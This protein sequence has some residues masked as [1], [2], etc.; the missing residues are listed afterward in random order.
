MRLGHQAQ[1]DRGLPGAPRP[2]A[3]PPP[4]R[5]AG[6][7]VPR[8]QPQ[9][10]PLL[11]DAAE[12]HGRPGRHRRRHQ[13]RRRA[14]AADHPG[15][16]PGRVHQEGQGE[17]A[18]LHGGLGPPEAERP[19]PAHRPVQG[20]LQGPATSGSRSSSPPCRG[21][22]MPSFRTGAVTELLSER[23][24][25]QRVRVDLG[26]D[27]P[28]RA[29]VLTQLTGP[30]AVGDRVV[31][32]TT[33]VELGLGTGGWHVVHWNLARESWSEPGPGH[34]MKLRYTSLQADTGAGEEQHPDVP[35]TL[36]GT[37]VVVCTVHSQVP[38]VVVAALAA[39]PGT[40]IA[41]VMTDG[42]ALPLAFSDLTA[43]HG[44]AGP[45]GRHGHGRARLRRRPRGGQR[46]LRP[47]P[48]PPRPRRRADRRRHGPRRGRHRHRRWAPPR[49]RRPR[50]LDTVAALGG[51]PVACLRVSS[52]DARDRHQGVSHHTRT[53]L[54]LVR[55][56]VLVAADARPRPDRAPRG[57][58]RST[59]PTPP[60]S[61][62]RRASTSR[63]WAAR[64]TRTPPTS[65]PPARPAC[66][67]HSSS[68]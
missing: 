66:W 1:P 24:G 56:P 46:G 44:R 5:P 3:G 58:R 15:P 51:R 37:P 38:C 61:W 33:A 53:V 26:D 54:D 14:P 8:R 41:Y 23:A 64:R 63:P 2:A 22:A 67:G 60:P 65:P 47:D 17:E 68:P 12:G 27:E 48:G 43:D 19:G 35:A 31:C 28:A 16:P 11:P 9:P 29:Y 49:W 18:G 13:P 42:A 62:P 45:A 40:R 52:G 21:A 25:L 36:D 55:S 7:A 6:P 57:G 10:W 39:R 32:N 4:G 34:I 30:V 59:P 20:P 50:A